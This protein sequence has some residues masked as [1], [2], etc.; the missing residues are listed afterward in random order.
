M[1]KINLQESE[2]QAAL[3][4]LNSQADGFSAGFGKT[5]DGDNQMDMADKIEEINSLYESIKQSYKDILLSHIQST[6][7]AVHTM[8]EKDEEISRA[9]RLVE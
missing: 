1:T 3:N 7:K 4:D 8:K 6:K 5:M 2:I 9:T